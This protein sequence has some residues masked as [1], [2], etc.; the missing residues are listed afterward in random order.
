MSQLR[1]VFLHISTSKDTLYFTDIIGRVRN[2]ETTPCRPEIF[3][4]ATD[5]TSSVVKLM[6]LCWIDNELE[7]PSFGSIRSYIKKNIKG[8]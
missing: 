6:Q 3:A 1:K 5:V 7:R 8:M 4:D 2:R